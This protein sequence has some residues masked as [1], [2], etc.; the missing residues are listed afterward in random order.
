MTA[1]ATALLWLRRRSSGQSESSLCW[2]LL[3]RS[4]SM[5]AAARDQNEARYPTER[6][7]LA[8]LPE[9]AALADKVTTDVLLI[10]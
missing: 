7:Q 9:L 6:T 2:R 8:S 3:L 4:G 5:P 10:R 1:L